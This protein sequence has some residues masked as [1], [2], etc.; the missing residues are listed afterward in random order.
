MAEAVDYWLD[1]LDGSGMRDRR[2]GFYRL[3]LLSELGTIELR[4]PR[5]RRFCPTRVLRNYARRAPEIDCAIL[6]GFVLGLSTRKVGEVLLALL[7][8]TVSA[9]TREPG[10]QHP[11]RRGGR[12][13]RPPA[14]QPI[15]GTHARRRGTRPRH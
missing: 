1:D 2:N 7:G 4:V 11:G 5:T 13:P 8:R 14:G 12:L 6:A 10:R 9:S 3:H 15:Q